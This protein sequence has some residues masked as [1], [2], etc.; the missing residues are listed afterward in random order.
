MGLSRREAIKIGI[1]GTGAL[2][3]P[4]GRL[5]SSTSPNRIAASALPLPYSVPLA[6][7]PVL[8]PVK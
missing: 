5:L 2:V 1:F 3:L 7:P 8:T 6:I 4:T